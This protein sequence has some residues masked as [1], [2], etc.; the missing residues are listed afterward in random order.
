ML[1][2]T[3]LCLTAAAALVNI[4]LA[5]RCGK[6]RAAEKINFGDGGNEALIRRMRA[7]SNFIEQVPVTLVLIAAVEMAG[8]GGVWLAPLGGVFI[9]GRLFHALG[10]DATGPKWGRPVGMLTSM[11]PQLGLAIVA[12]LAALGKI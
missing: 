12:V 1:L 11:V 4:W 7:Q 6:T 2:P 3:T 5:M 8:K 9:L 10:M